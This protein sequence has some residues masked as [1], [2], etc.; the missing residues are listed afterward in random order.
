[1]S[2]RPDALASIDIVTYDAMGLY[3]NIECFDCKLVILVRLSDQARQPAQC[4]CQ[5]GNK[6]AA[7]KLTTIHTAT[8]DGGPQ[9]YIQFGDTRFRVLVPGEGIP[10]VMHE[11]YDQPYTIETWFREGTERFFGAAVQKGVQDVPN[12]NWA[13]DPQ[14][15]KPALYYEEAFWEEPNGWTVGQGQERVMPDGLSWGDTYTLG[16]SESHGLGVPSR[17]YV[18][19]WAPASAEWDEYAVKHEE[20]IGIE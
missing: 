3:L 9:S 13:D 1:M 20:M 15:T 4:W 7:L 8:F 5:V 2:K 6:D 14:T 10:W 12:P 11:V 17:W 18:H 19:G 16:R